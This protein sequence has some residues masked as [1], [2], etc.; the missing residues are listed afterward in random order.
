MCVD[1]LV[2]IEINKDQCIHM[3]EVC[4]RE[5]YKMYIIDMRGTSYK[6]IVSV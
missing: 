3:L 2:K 4:P 6:R 5:V 1:G